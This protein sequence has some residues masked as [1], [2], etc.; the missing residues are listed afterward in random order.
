MNDAELGEAVRERRRVRVRIPLE[1]F[2]AFLR[3]GLKGSQAVRAVINGIPKDA[4]VLDIRERSFP[5]EFREFDVLL[6]HPDFDPVPEG[7]IIP[8]H[9]DITIET[10]VVLTGPSPSEVHGDFASFW[11][12][13]RTKGADLEA[14]G[15]EVDQYL[16]KFL[17]EIGYGEAADSYASM[18][19]W[20]A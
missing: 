17:T 10:R 19:T 4:Q 1:E 8:E 2:I 3:N 9:P 5:L 7:S 14:I 6:A 18:K 15:A 20:R 13:S 12:R 16:V 11:L